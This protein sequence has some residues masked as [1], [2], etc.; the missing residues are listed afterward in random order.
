MTLILQRYLL[1]FLQPSAPPRSPP[2]SPHTPTIT[3]LF[4]PRGQQQQQQR[5][6][7]GAACAALGPLYGGTGV[8]DAHFQRQGGAKKR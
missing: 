8:R 3:P 2:S 6:L 7:P 4:S 1:L 5:Q